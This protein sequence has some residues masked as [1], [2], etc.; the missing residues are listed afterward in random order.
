VRRVFPLALVFAL[1]GC[2]TPVPPPDE[3]LGRSPV[4]LSEVKRELLDASTDFAFR[5]VRAAKLG[6][7]GKNDCLSPFSLD[8]ALVILLNG[9]EGQSYETLAKGLGIGAHG[10]DH[11]NRSR[12]AVTDQLRSLPGPAVTVANSIWTVQPVPINHQYAADMKAF[13]GATVQKL[14]TAG[15]TGVRQVNDWVKAKT[16][17]RIPTLYRSLDPD[18][19]ILLVNTMTFDARW[20]T[21]FPP[22]QNRQFHSPTGTKGVPML[23]GVQN[24]GTVRSKAVDALRL[25]FEEG[26]L[27]LLVLLPKG[28]G[29]GELIGSLDAKVLG[30][31]LKETETR[32]EV[33]VQLPKFSFAV[34][35]DLRSLLT[36]VGCGPLFRPPND[37]SNISL[38]LRGGVFLDDTVQ[39]VWV[40]IDERGAK[41]AAATGIGIAKSV[42]EEFIVDRPF[43]FLVV[44]LA[45]R[46]V[47]LAGVVYDPAQ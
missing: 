47:V 26:G 9:A 45:S 34:Q 22:A 30:D 6:Q 8:Q 33:K 13:Y 23:V 38:Q 35:R 28:T 37:F 36:G 4:G 18:S 39:C 32:S 44:D 3:P 2:D 5:A 20:R 46:A 14:G 43:A 24:A 27:G 42:P 40:E 31:L 25:D 12:M 1:P 19:V 21:A 7:G 10:L 41:A 15:I 11:V 29:P 16:R 17:G